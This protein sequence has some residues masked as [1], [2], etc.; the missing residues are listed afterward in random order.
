MHPAPRTA[1]ALL[2]IAEAVS[3]SARREVPPPIDVVDTDPDAGVKAG[4]ASALA[5]KC[6]I[7]GLDSGGIVSRAGQMAPGS[8]DETPVPEQ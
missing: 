2:L 3:C 7:K 4:T 8:G 6:N 1:L 5:V